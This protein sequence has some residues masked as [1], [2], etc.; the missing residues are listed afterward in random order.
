MFV[1]LLRQALCENKLSSAKRRSEQ[2]ELE[3]GRAAQSAARACV[4][5]C[6]RDGK[7]DSF[8][9]FGSFERF[10]LNNR[11]KESQSAS[12]HSCVPNDTRIHYV[13]MH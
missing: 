1:L 9:R 5:A 10:V 8:A 6:V 3:A 12:R 2:R 4:R 11:F 7:P 13:R